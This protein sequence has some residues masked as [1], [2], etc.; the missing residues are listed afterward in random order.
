MVRVVCLYD[1]SALWCLDG[2]SLGL[3]VL[4]QSSTC[5][6]V[7]LLCTCGSGGPDAGVRGLMSVLTYYEKSP[8]H[9][10]QYTYFA[11]AVAV[12]LMQGFEV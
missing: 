7:H 11:R 9:V 3:H 6:A 5:A 2:G 10:Q 1:P 8:L 4:Y 12:V